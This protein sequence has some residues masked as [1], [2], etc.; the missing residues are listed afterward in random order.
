MEVSVTVCWQM[1]E[2]DGRHGMTGWVSSWLG[3]RGAQ[4]V[5]N[6]PQRPTS[7]QAL[8]SV[9]TTTGSLVSNEDFIS[10]FIM[11]KL[12]GHYFNTLVELQRL[13]YGAK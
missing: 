7:G 5:P 1:L 10:C 4:S 6:T 3:G 13:M 11:K 2:E 8:N 12:I 9:S